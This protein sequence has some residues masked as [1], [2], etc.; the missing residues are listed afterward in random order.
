MGTRIAHAAVLVATVTLALTGC[1]LFDALYDQGPPRN[2][3][4]AITE[5]KVVPATT[6]RVDDCF[7]FLED[8]SLEDVT[9]I[10]CAEEHSYIVIGQGE[11]TA[12]DV[13][14]AGGMQNAV[15]AACAE[16]FDTFKASAAEGS[17]PELQ[18][19]VANLEH[20]GET[21]S[22]YSCVATDGTVTASG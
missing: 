18:F 19:L 11:L 6:L 10:P 7:S 12:A 5:T 16:T 8:G 1:S 15:S 21:W 14:A 22:A 4:G 13:D 17:K 9:A 20:D 3:Q 2:D